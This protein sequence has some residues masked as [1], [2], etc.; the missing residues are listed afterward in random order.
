MMAIFKVEEIN[1]KARAIVVR[2]LCLSCARDV[3]VKASPSD[4]VVLWRD[5][6]QSRVTL[7]RNP[8]RFGYLADGKRGLIERIA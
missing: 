3:A 5:P 6:S 4:E 7:I 2:A 8:E 1:G